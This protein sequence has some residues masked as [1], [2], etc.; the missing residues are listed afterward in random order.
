MLKIKFKK[1]HLPKQTTVGFASPK[2]LDKRETSQNAVKVASL[3][4]SLLIILHLVINKLWPFIF[5][6]IRGVS[7]LIRKEPSVPLIREVRV[8]LK[9]RFLA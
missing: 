8:L 2:K 3:C 4:S 9:T 6:K 1:I 7:Y 5:G